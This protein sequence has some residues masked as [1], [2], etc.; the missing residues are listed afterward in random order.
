MDRLHVQVT[1][2]VTFPHKYTDEY[3]NEVVLN[4][5]GTKV[6]TCSQPLERVFITGNLILD[7]EE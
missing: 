5:D 1:E 2:K 3:G 7:K 4:E 6:T